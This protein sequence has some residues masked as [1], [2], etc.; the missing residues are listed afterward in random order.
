[1]STTYNKWFSNNDINIYDIKVT[2]AFNTIKSYYDREWLKY[3][4]S[5]E[6]VDV[7]EID[8]NIS[9]IFDDIYNQLT[10]STIRY[11]NLVTETKNIFPIINK[12][13]LLGEQYNIN[14]ILARESLLLLHSLITNQFQINENSR[15]F[16]SNQL[17]QFNNDLINN[18]YIEFIFDII[19]NKESKHKFTSNKN[20]IQQLLTMHTLNKYIN[21]N[22]SKT[23]LKYYLYIKQ[24]A[25]IQQV[26]I[27]GNNTIKFISNQGD[28]PS[29]TTLIRSNTY[30][31]NFNFHNLYVIQDSNISFSINNELATKYIYLNPISTLIDH[32]IPFNN[33]KVEYQNRLYTDRNTII[34]NGSIKLKPMYKNPYLESFDSKIQDPIPYLNY[35]FTIRDIIDYVNV[36]NTLESNSDAN[37][38]IN[39][40][41][42]IQQNHISNNNSNNNNNVQLINNSDIT[43][44]NTRQIMSNETFAN[45]K[46]DIDQ[47]KQKIESYNFAK[48]MFDPVSSD[49]F[50]DNDEVAT[51]MLKLVGG[52]SKIDLLSAFIYNIMKVKYSLDTAFELNKIV[53]DECFPGLEFKDNESLFNYSLQGE[54]SELINRVNNN[55]N[56]KMSKAFQFDNSFIEDQQTTNSI[57]F[58]YH[59]NVIN[60]SLRINSEV[61][62]GIPGM[63]SIGMG[64]QSIKSLMYNTYSHMSSS[65][66]TFDI[67][68]Q[69][70]DSANHKVLTQRINIPQ[71]NSYYNFNSDNYTLFGSFLNWVVGSVTSHVLNTTKR[72]ETISNKYNIPLVFP[73]L[74]VTP[75]YSNTTKQDWKPIMK[76]SHTRSGIFGHTLTTGATI[77]SNTI[78]KY[79]D[80]K[81]GILSPTQNYLDFISKTK[82]KAVNTLD[83][84]SVI[85]GKV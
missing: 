30:R 53:I 7:S 13:Q 31:N 32:I 19:E 2:N 55:T 6:Q 77:K 43:T 35:F 38:T 66:L 33:D 58:N 75:V 34:N 26:N 52:E 8:S 23:L 50:N 48:Y 40:I 72:T 18:A 29:I 3:Y 5:P 49:L 69:L 46:N 41:V 80:V 11:A 83:I 56:G 15:E 76:Y 82:I 63:K 84:L 37:E 65:V 10:L 24:P 4:H 73:L 59:N 54:T 21:V 1:M 68:A 62:A 27:H 79:I 36:D 47:Y 78:R 70:F 74:S 42:T 22:V 51:K 85:K 44:I 20:I 28:D 64:L 60:S 9:E 67:L 57:N 25:I 14:N 12:P 39:D 16:V 81:L 45:F 61:K 17:L 71:D